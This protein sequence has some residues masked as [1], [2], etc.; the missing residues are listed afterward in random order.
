VSGRPCAGPENRADHVRCE[1]SCPCAAA[2]AGPP[3]VKKNRYIT[4]SSS[5]NPSNPPN[6]IPNFSVVHCILEY[7]VVRDPHCGIVPY[8]ITPAE[9]VYPAILPRQKSA[10]MS[11]NDEHDHSGHG[12]GH[13][14]SHPH[15][16]SDDI[17]PAVQNL[18]YDQIDFPNINT[19]N[20]DDSN[21]G[22]A[23]VQKTWAERLSVEPELKSSADEQLLIIVP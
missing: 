12:H 22:R 17:T 1:K 14:H 9:P 15:D 20:E 11:C 5:H 10:V 13:D 8:Y 4:P 21:S 7:T 6:T 18:L 19:L 23:I 3:S 2:E 16:H